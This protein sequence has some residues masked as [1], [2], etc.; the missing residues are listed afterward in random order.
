[1]NVWIIHIVLPPPHCHH[2]SNPYKQFFFFRETCFG[3]I[4]RPL[5]KKF[6]LAPFFFFLSCYCAA[7]ET[8]DANDRLDPQ[9]VRRH[10]TIFLCWLKTFSIPT[11]VKSWLWWTWVGV[12][13][14]GP[15]SNSYEDFYS[16][17]V[18]CKNNL[19]FFFRKLCFKLMG[20]MISFKMLLWRKYFWIPV[21]LIFME[22]ISILLFI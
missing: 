13:K 8:A 11:P 10:S 5:R 6:I 2:F 18:K 20:K 22:V 7:G 16:I 4:F 14:T 19:F 9:S 1:M 15:K 12:G 3:M 21:L 17:A